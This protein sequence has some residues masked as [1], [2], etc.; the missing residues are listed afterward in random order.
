MEIVLVTYSK[1]LDKADLCISTIKKYGVGP[2]QFKF[3]V[4]IND[5]ESVYATA[6][7]KWPDLSVY[8]W[9][10]I[11]PTLSW[12]SGWWSQQWLKL[13]ASCVV[14][15]DWYMIVDSDMFLNR[16][17]DLQELFYNE[18]A[19]VS[20]K[21]RSAYSDQ[22]QFLEF[23]DNARTFVG[24]DHLES[25]MRAVPPQIFRTSVALDLASN[26]DPRIFGILGQHTTEFFLYWAWICKHNQIEN[27]YHPLDNWL[28]MGTGFFT[29][30]TREVAYNKNYAI[31]NL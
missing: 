5:I 13:C 29:Q 17:I 12:P 14:E 31:I 19:F 16:H 7:L 30:P 28:T 6:K 9:K 1:D 4:I 25:V 27:F 23:I 21:P 24:L 15:E 10:D 22:P 20:L 2:Y 8:H 3:R 26:I 11:S 18:R